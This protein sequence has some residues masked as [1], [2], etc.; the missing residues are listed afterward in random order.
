MRSV[1]H[2]VGVSCPRIMFVL[3]VFKISILTKN[4]K[5]KVFYYGLQMRWLYAI[6]NT[7]TVS[8]R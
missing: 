1:R 3:A 8:N 4:Q 2:G 5:G 6:I 7:N